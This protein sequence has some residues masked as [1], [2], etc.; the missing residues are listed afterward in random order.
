MTK[1]RSHICIGGMRRGDAQV[2]FKSLF[3]ESFLSIEIPDNENIFI[4][5]LAIYSDQDIKKIKDFQQE[6]KIKGKDRLYRIITYEP[7]DFSKLM[8]KT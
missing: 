1:F 2:K 7:I 3:R 4:L 6:I 5:R 8:S